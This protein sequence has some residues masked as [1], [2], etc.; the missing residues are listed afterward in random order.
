MTA[1]VPRLVLAEP[2]LS[3]QVDTSRSPL[4][5]GSGIALMSKY[6][7]VPLNDSEVTSAACSDCWTAVRIV[8]LT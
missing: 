8:G 4:T 2:A 7:T 3:K 5:S 6:L 1:P